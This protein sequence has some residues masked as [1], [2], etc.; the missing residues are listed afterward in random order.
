MGNSEKLSAAVL[1]NPKPDQWGLRGDPSLWE[2]MR[3][4]FETV[5]MPISAEEFIKNFNDL[6]E[7]FTGVPLTLDCQ[8]SVS[9]YDRGGISG[10][11]VSGA[12]WLKEALPMLL[13]RLKVCSL[14]INVEQAMDAGGS[15]NIKQQSDIIIK[16][17]RL[18]IR[19]IRQSDR[20]AISVILQ[21]EAV[22]Y[23]W[24]HAF[25]DEEVEDWINQNL[26]RYDR[27]GY[28]YWAVI[29]KDTD[30]LI[31]LCGLISEKANEA[32]Y[33]GVGYIFGKKYWHN[34]Y[35]LE[36]AS[37]CVEYAFDRFGV[38]QVTAQIRPENLSSVKV[39]EK[40]G[41]T[42]AL[43]FVKKYRG[44]EMIHDLYVISKKRKS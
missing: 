18:Y 6:F 26:L 40:L 30:E 4:S 28:S 25:S 17:P 34:G 23:A 41:M 36:S 20:P 15:S 32:S 37:A 43:R 29:K 5:G 12:F 33:L 24:E 31:G 14:T 22:M 19:K 27:D 16:T 13:E 42:P 11:Q 7:K 44:K 1:F 21:D 8:P 10:G 35:A 3:R 39:A 9:M 2:E 38:K